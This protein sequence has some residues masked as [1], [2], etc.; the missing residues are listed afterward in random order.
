M[1]DLRYVYWDSNPF[2][3]IFNKE[4]GRLDDCLKVIKAAEAGELKIVTSSVTLAEV[5][6]VRRGT[7]IPAGKEA[8]LYDFFQNDFIVFVNVEWFIGNA[9]RRLV[10]KYPSLKPMDAIHLATAIKGKV[11]EMHTYDSGLLGMSGK[12]GVP[13]LTI[14]HP[15]LENPPLIAV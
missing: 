13:P 15:S 7:P 4:A 11:S 8:I 2:C 6:K 9:A 12:V 1:A 14:C 5:V 3:A 10:H